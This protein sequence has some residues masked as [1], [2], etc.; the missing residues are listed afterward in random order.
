MSVGP[1][2][3]APQTRC[4]AARARPSPALPRFRRGRDF[5]AERAVG[6]PDQPRYRVAEMVEHAADFAVLALLQRQGQPG[7]RSLRPVERGADR[8]VGDAVDRD[9]RRQRREAGG[10]DRAVHAHAIA[11]DPAGRRQ[12]EAA[13]QPAVIGQQQQPL[14]IQIEPADRDQPRQTRGQRA[15]YGRPALLVAMRRD[16]PDSFVIAPQARPVGFR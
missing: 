5:R 9:A 3:R 2:P 13:G 7:V 8:A 14:G 10:L 16:Q 4:R 6:D 1:A 12:F 11:P 15:E